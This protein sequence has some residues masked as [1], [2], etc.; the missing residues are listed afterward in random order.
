MSFKDHF[1]AQAADYA[2]YRPDYPQ[3]IYDFILLNVHNSDAAW[4][5]GT[6][7]GQ[8]AVALANYFEDVMATDPSA[9]QIAN[10]SRVEN[11][12]Y[13]I[14]PAEASGLPSSYFDVITVGQAAH[15]FQFDEFYAEVRRVAKPGAL[16]MMWGYG[17][18]TVTPEVD[19]VVNHFYYHTVGSFWPPERQYLDNEYRDLPFPFTPL[20]VAPM[21]M[22]QYW[23]LA[24]FVG[25]LNTWSSVQGYIR[26]HGQNPVQALVPALAK[27]WGNADVLLPI[28]WPLYVKAAFV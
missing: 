16:L 9:Q 10:A 26:A 3:E 4:D 20:S 22:V 13:S 24:D 12:T 25:Y 19:A 28:T 2:R 1:S 15:W 17:L 8:V 27:A 11:V 14:A 5:C 23:S 6:G 21:Q 7:N 18:S